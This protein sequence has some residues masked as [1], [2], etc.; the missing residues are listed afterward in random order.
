MALQAGH[1]EGTGR[2]CTHFVPTL[3]PPQSMCSRRAPSCGPIYDGNVIIHVLTWSAAYGLDWVW[4][5]KL[6]F[7]QNRIAIIDDVCVIH[8]TKATQ[9]LGK[10]SMYDTMTMLARTE[11]KSAF[12]RYHYT[13]RVRGVHGVRA[14]W[15]ESVLCLVEQMAFMLC[16]TSSGR[17]RGL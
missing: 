6:G 2:P 11:E 17:C 9:S 1:S 16:S 13:G 8:P 3:A 5:F 12:K 4:P 14:A 10:A 15:H 7:P